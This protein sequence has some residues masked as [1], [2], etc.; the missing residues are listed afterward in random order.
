LGMPFEI[1]RSRSTPPFAGLFLGFQHLRLTAIGRHT[2]K[3]WGTSAS[4]ADRA[5]PPT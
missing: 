2:Q 4:E 3:P 1:G 5:I